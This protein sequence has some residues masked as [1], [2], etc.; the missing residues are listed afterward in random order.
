MADALAVQ[1]NHID[2]GPVPAPRSVE[3]ILEGAAEKWPDRVALDFYD[4]V[5]TFRDLHA[6]ALQAAKGFER[7]GVRPG[8]NVA[9]HLPN[10]PHFV[11]CFFGVMIAGGCVV[12]CSPRAGMTELQD[13]LRDS[14]AEIL[15]TA[16]WQSHCPQLRRLVGTDAL[17][18]LVICSLMDFLTEERARELVSQ[19]CSPEP[20]TA[21]EVT[22]TALI[23]NG[24][25]ATRHPRGALDEEVAV[26]QYTGGTTGEPKAAMLTHANFSAC[27]HSSERL[28]GA[29]TQQSFKALAILPLHHIYGLGLMLRAVASG[30]QLV[31]HIR[32]DAGKVLSDIQGKKINLLAAVPSMFSRLAQHSSF[33]RCDFSSVMGY[34]SAGAPLPGHLRGRLE[35]RVELMM[36]DSYALTETTGVGTV[37]A[38]HIKGAPGQVGIPAPF[39]RIEVV[40]LDTGLKVLPRG[41]IG[42]LCFTGPHVMKGYWNRPE[43]N[44]EVFRGGRF[45]T[46]DIGFIDQRGLVTLTE[47]KKDVIFTGGHNVYPRNI[48]RAILEHP[49]VAEVAVVGVPHEDFGEVAKAFVVLEPGS[50]RFS[51][52]DLCGFLS[53][54]VA[55]YEIPME[56]EIR[57]ELPETNLSKISKRALIAEE[58]GARARDG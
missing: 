44:A 27:V 58:A 24:T 16:D 6:L 12:N 8:V 30:L 26:L 32:F 47:R 5:H 51:F 23:A 49:A 38:P 4:T 36:K 42:E 50:A 9:L 56:M 37:P 18:A 22:F 35:E 41:E 7:L 25:A 20:T 48:E 17:R 28:A 54:R 39:A 21:N 33:G 19:V 1:P 52:T 46:G 31:L 14:R 2:W 11:V 3:S 57:A 45:H 34:A 29:R 10:T 13:Q 55:S 53:Q 15:V 40:D 43:D